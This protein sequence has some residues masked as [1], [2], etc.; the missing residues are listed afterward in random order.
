[1]KT[2]RTIDCQ[3]GIYDTEY[4]AVYHRDGSITVKEPYIKWAGNTGCLAFRKI[5]LSGNNATMAKRFF[6]NDELVSDSVMILD[7]ILY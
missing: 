5:R 7:D 2:N 4:T 3:V 1:M 6:K